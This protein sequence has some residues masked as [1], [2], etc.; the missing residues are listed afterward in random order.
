MDMLKP[1]SRMLRLLETT[2]TP[3]PD[4]AFTPFAA[5]TS[6]EIHYAQQ[7]RRRI[8]ER[9]LNRPSTPVCPWTVGAD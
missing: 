9:Y 2:T 8:E 5:A 1:G 6:E 3:S 7:L 4:P